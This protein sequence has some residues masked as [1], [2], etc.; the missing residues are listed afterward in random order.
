MSKTIGNVADPF[1]IIE[2]LIKAGVPRESATDA[3]RYYLLREI[4]TGA[5]GDF[6]WEKFKERYNADLANGLGNFISR[7]YQLAGMFKADS[8]EKIIEDNVRLK[9]EDTTRLV[10]EKIKQFKL[11]EAI[12]AIAELGHFGDD[13]LSKAEPWLRPRPE[14]CIKTWNA[15]FIAKR[16]SELLK[17]FLP[18]TAE[19]IVSAVNK[20]ENPTYIDEKSPYGNREKLD[21]LFPRIS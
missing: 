21:P 15:I 7:S 16:I 5:D 8:G 19:K 2:R 17:S 4:P 20:M 13:F 6:S 14:A 3:L 1:E 10:D 12:E 11:N 18:D 9:A